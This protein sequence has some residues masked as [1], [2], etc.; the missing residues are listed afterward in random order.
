[1]MFHNQDKQHHTAN[2]PWVEQDLWFVSTKCTLS[3]NC[4]A[5]SVPVRRQFYEAE[6][7]SHKFNLKLFL[8][9]SL[10]KKNHIEEKYYFE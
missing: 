6:V 3:Y 4:T 10:N 8:F 9:I 2:N 1:M 7:C 5:L